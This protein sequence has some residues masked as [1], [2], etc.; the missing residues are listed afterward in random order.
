MSDCVTIMQIRAKNEKENTSTH[1]CR[2]LRLH[3]LPLVGVSKTKVLK[4]TMKPN[5]GRK[6]GPSERLGRV[7]FSFRQGKT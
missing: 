3:Y 1:V 4:E 5:Q 2:N 6:L 7:T